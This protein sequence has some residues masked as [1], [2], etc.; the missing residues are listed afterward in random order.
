MPTT[1]RPSKIFYKYYNYITTQKNIDLQKCIIYNVHK[2]KNKTKNTDERKDEK[3]MKNQNHTSHLALHT[4][5]RGI[6]LIALIITIIVMLILVGVTINVALNGGLFEKATEAKTKT[7]LAADREELQMAVI[8]VLNNNLE[9]PKASA[10]EIEGWTITGN[11]GGPYTCTSPNGNIFTVDNKGN[12]T[13]GETNSDGGNE[14]L[15]FDWKTVNLEI[16]TNAYYEFFDTNFSTTYVIN[17]RDDGNFILKADD[18]EVGTFKAVD[19]KDGNGN[20]TL[21]FTYNGTTYDTTLTMN[22]ENIDAELK[23]LTTV[24][25]TKYYPVDLTKP[26]VYGTENEFYIIT[27]DNRYICVAEGEKA[28]EATIRKVN[29]ISEI[30]GHSDWKVE[31]NGNSFELYE[32]KFYL[33]YR[34]R[35][36]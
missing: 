35:S 30:D 34:T 31:S 27:T 21:P 16:D 1:T 12:I 14:P 25:Y 26:L 23:G 28:I 24:I 8:A 17:F 18:V 19:Y 9:I 7:Q 5:E 6:T 11:D 29:S 20:I 13:E 32:L 33:L 2:Y 4:S 36:R 22:G 10:I 15:A 3:H